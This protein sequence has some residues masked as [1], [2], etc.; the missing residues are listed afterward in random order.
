MKGKI[1]RETFDKNLNE[2]IRLKQAEDGRSFFTV[3]PKGMP[4]EHMQS[5][6]KP[7]FAHICVTNKCNLNCPYCYAADHNVSHDMTDE[8]LKQV[9]EICNN[10]DIMCITWTGGEPLLRSN[11]SEIVLQVYK[12]GIKQTILTN[13]TLLE[14]IIGEKWPTKNI[15]FQVSLNNIWNN[16]VECAPIIEKVKKMIKEGYDIVVTVMLE[17]K[18][19]ELYKKLFDMLV[20]NQISKIRLGFKIPVGRGAF[21]GDMK[22]YEKKMREIIPGLF[23]LKEKYQGILKID[24]QFEDAN[25]KFSGLPRRFMIC[26]AGTMEVYIDNNGNAY[27][28]PLFKSYE[29]LYCGNVFDNS[30]QSIWQSEAMNKLR[31]VNECKD[32]SYICGVWCR[33]LKTAMDGSFYGKSKYCL[34]TME[35]I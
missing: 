21:D 30:W 11:F 13:G 31:K 22:E 15:N 24:Y 32:C 23:K 10:N 6:E 33:A 20:E 3:V 28:C 26:Q 14:T 27:P 18:S 2:V 35:R 9:V 16:Y 17:P 8:Q 19:C 25:Y 12:Y 1:L 29:D 5:L 7:L 34:K 4:V